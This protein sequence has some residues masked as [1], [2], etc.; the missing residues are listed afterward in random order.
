MPWLAIPF[1]DS[2]TR[3]RLD[4]S[5]KVMGIPYLVILDENGKVVTEEGVEFI[6]DFGV[7]AYPFTQERI[8]EI[9]DEEEKAKREQP[10]KF[11]LASRSRDFVIS[12]NGNKVSLHAVIKYC[13]ANNI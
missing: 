2:S 11:V 13:G 9:E 7:D 6:R 4:A 10:L 8:K 12:A 1:S 5:F 3:D